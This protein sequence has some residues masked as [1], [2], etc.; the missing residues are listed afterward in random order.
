[1]RRASDVA[2]RINSG[3][4][5]RLV[6]LSHVA[7]EDGVREFAAKISAAVRGLGLHHPR[8]RAAKF[9]T[10]SYS[11]SVMQA[12]SENSNAKDFLSNVLQD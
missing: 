5:D 9:V 1:L 8:S 2:A 11:T 7:D 4:V 12:G 3:D 10:V 6:I